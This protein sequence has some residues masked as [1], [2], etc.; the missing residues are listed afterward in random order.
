L[1][2]LSTNTSYF[3]GLL[4]SFKS[5]KDGKIKLQF[6]LDNNLRVSTE[7]KPNINMMLY[8]DA[9][10]NSIEFSYP[11]VRPIVAKLVFFAGYLGYTFSFNK[12][13]LRFSKI[14]AEGWELIDIF[15]SLVQIS[16]INTEKYM[17]HGAAVTLGEE[18]ILVPSF[19]N[20]GKTTTSWMLA[21]RGAEFLTD[22]FAIL[23]SQGHCLGFPCSSLV[24]G[25]LVK[26]AELRLTRKQAVSLW[27]RELM[28]KMVSTR[29]APGGIKL[30]PDQ[31]FKMRD[32]AAITR[33]VFIQK[34]FDHT[35]RIDPDEA[36]TLLT[37]VQD[38]EMNWRANPYIIAQ[39]FFRPDFNPRDQSLKET[40]I[41]RSIVSRAKAAYLV[42]SSNKSHFESIEEI[43][44]KSPK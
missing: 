38:Y 8:H 24:S 20:T 5:D 17:V 42:S 39:S 7:G 41:V 33:I 26:A 40:E 2:S 6:L 9:Q 13:Y 36:V 30:Y 19:G 4:H 18:G 37:A 35:R 27:L 34:G 14:V 15:R 44:Q 11:W 12:N 21:K 43:V 23:D 29:F 28:S 10:D 22:E 31:I 25:P 3:E 16:L 32:D 1:F